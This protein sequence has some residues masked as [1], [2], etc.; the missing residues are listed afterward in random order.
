MNIS[1]DFWFFLSG[2]LPVFPT[3]LI[4]KFLI[5]KLAQQRVDFVKQAQNRTKLGKS[6]FLNYHWLP[7]K[8]HYQKPSYGTKQKTR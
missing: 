6:F 7:V 8:T 5:Y 1:K 4:Y 2:I 3:D